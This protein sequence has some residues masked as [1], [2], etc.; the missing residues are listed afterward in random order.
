M[1]KHIVIFVI[2][3]FAAPALAVAD[4]KADYNAKCA[5][6]HGAHGNVQTEKARALNMDVKK[7][8]LKISKKNKDEM[9]AI[10]E[11]GKGAMPGFKKDLNKE[12]VTGIVLYI[13][14]LRKSPGR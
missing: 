4:G 12:Q 9:T 6:C 3:L 8:S 10:I 1:K 14:A 11:N 5:G 7:L 13:M 2:L